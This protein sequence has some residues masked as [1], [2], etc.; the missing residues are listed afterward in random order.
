MLVTL[1]KSL[2]SGGDSRR[3]CEKRVGFTFKILHLEFG[4]EASIID[5]PVDRETTLMLW[6]V[7]AREW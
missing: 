2:F 4:P 6:V 1:A 5:Y 3:V 7:N